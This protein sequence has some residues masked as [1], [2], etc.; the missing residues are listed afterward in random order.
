M[1]SDNDFKIDFI[2]IGA[3]KCATTWISQCLKEHPSICMSNPKETHYFLTPN[4]KKGLKWYQLCFKHCR[5]G[6][7]QTRGEFT[8]RYMIHIETA[9][10]IRE[11]NSNIKLIA[12]LRN[13]V[14]R[15]YSSYFH[16]KSVR[17]IGS[18]LTFEEVLKKDIEKNDILIR[19][20]L[21]YSYLKEFYK[22]F[23]QENILILIYEDI[24]KDPVKF[25]QTIYEFL[26]VDKNIVPC[27]VYDQVNVATGNRLKISLFKEIFRSVRIRATRKDTIFFASIYK[28]LKLMGVGRIAKIVRRMNRK[29]ESKIEKLEKPPMKEETKRYLDNL[30]LEDINNLEK[31]INKDLSHWKQIIIKK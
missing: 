16:L 13:P 31:L 28:F 4:Y 14:E 17:S 24:K 21:Y 25:I 6:G 15:T 26:G 9:E 11:H 29:Q 19:P 18:R 27:S 12:C 23:L 5:G 1:K 8:T 7:E 2:G 22:N 3:P 20:S 10:R 30:F